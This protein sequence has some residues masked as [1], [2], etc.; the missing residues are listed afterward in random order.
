V[1]TATAKQAVI[2][3]L[4]KLGVV[5]RRTPPQDA[6]IQDGLDA[7]WLLFESLSAQN[8]TIGFYQK[9]SF[10]LNTTS[11]T[12]TLGKGA[13]LD[14]PY[15]LEIQSIQLV[16]SGGIYHPVTMVQGAN[17][18]QNTNPT[19]EARNGMPSQVIWN[20]S[21]PAGTLEFN[22]FFSSVYTLVVTAKIPWTTENGSEAQSS[23]DAG[24]P[25]TASDYLVSVDQT[26][27]LYC[28]DNCVL[29]V[30]QQMN[31]W[32]EDQRDI[33]IQD[34]YQETFNYNGLSVV[35]DA[36]LRVRTKPNPIQLSVNKDMELAIGDLPMIIW[37]LAAALLTEYPQDDPSVTSMIISQATMHLAQTKNRNTTPAKIQA[38]RSYRSNQLQNRRYYGAGYM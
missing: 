21:I 25:V 30:T 37:N 26:T 1:A 9:F 4:K 29:D 24:Q 7:L 28:D 38:S 35:A 5:T 12:F 23:L 34:S 11:R 27:Q 14:M 20:P 31:D 17:Y 36:T 19:M 22:A 32:L 2:M 15:P 6:D 13:D 16:D 33:G 18:F 8:A 10:T 3:A